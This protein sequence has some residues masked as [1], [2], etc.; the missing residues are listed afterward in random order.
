MG[1]VYCPTPPLLPKTPSWIMLPIAIFHQDTS[2]L[3]NV[4]TKNIM[5]LC[6]QTS[7]LATQMA[8]FL[9]MCWIKSLYDFWTKERL[10]CQSQM[11]R[12]VTA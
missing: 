9:G 8:T 6:G 1:T 5:R 12:T 3:V 11:G 4:C 10:H 7:T 2:I